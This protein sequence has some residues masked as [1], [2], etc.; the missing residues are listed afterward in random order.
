MKT[1]SRYVSWPAFYTEYAGTRGLSGYVDGSRLKARFNAPSGLVIST[2]PR[3]PWRIYI[4]D[5]GNH[6]IRVVAY[7]SGRIATV[8][9]SPVTKGWRDGPGQEAKFEQPSSLGMDPEGLHL[10]VL[11]NFR[12]IRYIQLYL[13]K[14]TVSTLVGGACRAVARWTVYESIVQRRVGCHP[15]AWAIVG[16]V[17]GHVR[18]SGCGIANPMQ[19]TYDWSATLAGEQVDVYVSGEGIFKCTGHQATCAPRNHPALADR[20]STQLLSKAYAQSLLE[21]IP[22]ED[23][24]D[25]PL[26]LPGVP[27]GDRIEPSDRAE[28]VPAAKR[29]TRRRALV[30]RANARGVAS[31]GG[32]CG[33]GKGSVRRF[34]C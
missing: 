20:V 12:R 14:K 23:P 9:G 7:E 15:V 24:Y 5:S 19:I 13:K 10:F 11:D 34:L 29:R 30:G 3:R 17:G 2:D 31:G 22:P 21:G 26:V 18:S 25:M 4:A 28:C 8:A 32:L 6:C 16:G 1:T 33:V 27:M